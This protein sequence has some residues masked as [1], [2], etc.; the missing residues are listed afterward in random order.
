MFR[1]EK[2]NLWWWMG[3]NMLRCG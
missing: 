1:A 3:W 2:L